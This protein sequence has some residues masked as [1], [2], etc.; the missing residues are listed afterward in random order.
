[1]IK[2]YLQ[3]ALYHLRENPAI[4]LISLVGTALS[5]AM[6]MVVVITLRARTADCVPEVNRSRCLYVPNMS[7]RLKENTGGS[8]NSCMSVQTGRECF[9][10][11]TVPEAVTLISRPSKV[12]ASLPVGEK[13]TADMVETDDAFWR[14]F[15]F[16]FLD[17]KPFTEADFQSGLP[18]AVICAT[19]AR[20]LFGQTE[21]VAGRRIQLNHVDF[22]VA[23]VVADVS[24][25]A[26]DSYAQVWIPYTAGSSES[27]S[28]GY[29]LMGPMRAVIL[30]RSADDLP[31]IREEC[32]RLRRRYNDAQGD[33]EVFYRGQPDTHFTHLYRKWSEEPDMQSTVLRYVAIILIL[34]IV[35]A[36][37]LSS[38]TLSRMRRR[39]AE[40]GVRRAFGAT[41]GELMT[42]VLVENLLVTLVGGLV[43]LLLSYGATFLLN[44][45]LFGNSTNAYLMGETTLTAGM[46]L[47][48]WIFLAAFAFCLVMN[49]LSAGL[50]AWRASRMSIVEAIAGKAH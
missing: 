46:L 43:G 26:T 22:Q 48:P 13:L 3:Q 10:A 14:V 20:H 36:I 47:S 42:Q 28:W 17:G 41:E 31:A 38:M 32:E 49:L 9:K 37:N 4:S 15:Q 27:L 34:L 19:V 18:R 1:M 24:T 5:I 25:L 7:Y 23:G 21:G 35:P 16:R 39:M 29:N 45:F 6:I 12:R 11:L 8:S 2:Q 30:A 50:P 44:G 33:Y 40:I